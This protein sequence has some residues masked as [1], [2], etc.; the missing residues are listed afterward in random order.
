METIRNEIIKTLERKLGK[1]YQIIPWD[2]TKNNGIIRHGICIRKG[3]ERISPLIYLNEDE[4][5]AVGD[6][7]PE[8]IAD[9]L[10]KAYYQEKVPQNAAAGL[11]DFDWAKERIRIKVTNYDANLEVLDKSPHRKFLDLAI[12]YYLEMDL[13]GQGA[14]FAITNELME[15]WGITEDELYRIGMEKLL[16]K[17]AC[18]ITEMFKLLRQIAQDEQDEMTEAAVAELEKD[19][20]RLEIYVASNQKR[21]FGANCL[22]NIPLLQELAEDRGC[23]LMIYP[24]SVHEIILFPLKKGKK[25]CLS[26]KDVQEIN[27]RGVPRDEWLSNSIYRYDREK[28][29]VSVY[30]KGAPLSW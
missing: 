24:S 8:D 25:G 22:L 19:R 5:S 2:K 1:E 29:E 30:K 11:W 13:D 6:V 10:L 4:Y 17:D 14:F 21:S 18:C 23:S 28:K 3:N 15:S 27:T 12:T 26:T 9:T 20:N 7:N 16:A